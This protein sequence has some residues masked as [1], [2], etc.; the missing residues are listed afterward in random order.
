M[1]FP[2]IV[3]PSVLSADFADVASGLGRIESA[4]AE[5]VHLDVMDGHFV[6]TISFGPAM[7]AAIRR[8]TS[9]PLD[10]HLMIEH[11]DRSFGAYVEAG[12][13]YL[14]FHI[15][16]VVHAHR[17]VEAIRSSGARPGISIVPSTPVALIEELLPMV[18]LVLVMTVNP[19]FGGQ[20]MIP[21]TL[22]KVARLHA[23]RAEHRAGYRIS[24][25][26]GINTETAPS[27]REAGADV[28]VSGSA[29]FTAPDPS[30]YLQ[31]LRG[32]GPTIA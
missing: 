22:E 15:E 24:V 12:A 26:G 2:V 13:D 17:L 5:W 20:A 28:L 32:V 30:T 10:V 18:D 21:A 16:S 19:G 8:R 23:W 9:L 4:G 25:D 11:P 3:A 14:T 31:E 1:S 27:A 6:P 29:F 7:V